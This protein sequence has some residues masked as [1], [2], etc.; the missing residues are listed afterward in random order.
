MEQAL[1]ARKKEFLMAQYA[2]TEMMEDTATTKELA[3]K[4]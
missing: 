3:Q 1:L 2:S 4:K